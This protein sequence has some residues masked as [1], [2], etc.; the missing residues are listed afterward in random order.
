MLGSAH[1][2]FP[3]AVSQTA[4]G[5]SSKQYLGKMKREKSLFPKLSFLMFPTAV[6]QTAVG[7]SICDKDHVITLASQWCG[8]KARHVFN[9]HFCF[10]A[11]KDLFPTAVS[12]TT[13]GNR[14]RIRL[15]QCCLTNDG[16]NEH[17]ADGRKLSAM[18]GGDIF[19][20]T[21]E[22]FVFHRLLHVHGVTP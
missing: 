2:L 16:G 4:V 20:A 15:S 9:F 3:T 14:C 10:M 5:T 12:Q 6:S 21:G 22:N 1:V 11:A 7:N 13:V 19:A 8:K 17:L 18:A